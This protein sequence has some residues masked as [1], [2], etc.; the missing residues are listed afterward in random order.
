MHY[1]AMKLEKSLVNLASNYI[2]KC[3]SNVLND[4]SCPER[5][6]CYLKDGRLICFIGGPNSFI[7]DPINKS[8]IKKISHDIYDFDISKINIEH[9]DKII[10]KKSIINKKTDEY[11][12]VRD[13]YKITKKTLKQ[14]DIEEIVKYEQSLKTSRK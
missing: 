3:I 9:L 2:N 14:K 1:L 5:L 10:C 7:Y 12:F 13:K 6:A 4:I 8:I 11:S